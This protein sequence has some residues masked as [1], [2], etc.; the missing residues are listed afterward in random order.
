MWMRTLSQYAELTVMEALG[1]LGFDDGV[2]TATEGME[3][4][5]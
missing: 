4:L 1:V 5:I 2:G 3:N